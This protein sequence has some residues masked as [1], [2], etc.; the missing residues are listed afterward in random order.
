MSQVD[1]S[2]ISWPA[3][4]LVLPSTSVFFLSDLLASW[5]GWQ[6]DG[7]GLTQAV[8]GQ[9]DAA[10]RLYILAGLLACCGAV[11]L[12]LLLGVGEMAR[13]FRPEMRRKFLATLAGGLVLGTLWVWWSATHMLAV[14]DSLGS[15]L[16]GS[17]TQLFA[18]GP[19]IGADALQTRFVAI[20][21]IG[22]L[23]LMLGAGFVIVGGVSCMARLKE[24]ATQKKRRDYLLKQRERLRFYVN[25]AAILM[26]AAIAFLVAWSRWPLT[27]MDEATAK[28]HLALVNAATVYQGATLTLVIALF[29][30]PVAA[31]LRSDLARLPPT[32]GEAAEDGTQSSLF[33]PLGK[34][35]AVLAPALASVLPALADIAKSGS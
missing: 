9:A 4:A 29:A 10:G 11:F 19:G 6:G 28:T 22:R 1:D 17:A 3:L 20:L 21:V 14:Q 2:T 15:G 31:A 25:A 7:P 13:A 35:L 30:V 8:T 27:L 32:P 16:F 5:F 33:G 26:V 24:P 18:G 23:A 12:T 34:I